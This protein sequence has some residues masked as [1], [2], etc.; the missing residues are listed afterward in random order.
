MHTQATLGALQL[1]VD[2]TDGES[3]AWKAATTK[4]QATIT[5][6]S[7]KNRGHGNFDI[8]VDVFVTVTSDRTIDQKEAGKNR[9]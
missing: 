9:D 7:I 4:A 5:G 3:A 1:R 2:F 8:V 6:P